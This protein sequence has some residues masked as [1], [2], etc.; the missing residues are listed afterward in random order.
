MHHIPIRHTLCPPFIHRPCPME[1][2]LAKVCN[3][4]KLMIS[5]PEFRCYIVGGDLVNLAVEKFKHIILRTQRIL[6]SNVM[7]ALGGSNDNYV[8]IISY[9]THIIYDLP[10]SFQKCTWWVSPNQGWNQFREKNY[11]DTCDQSVQ[12]WEKVVISQGQE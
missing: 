9:T 2:I 6:G 5:K 11:F 1:L 4:R 12:P 8:D 10:A 7:G 3:I